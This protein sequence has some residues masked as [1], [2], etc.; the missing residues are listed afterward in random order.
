MLPKA[1]PAVFDGLSGDAAAKNTVSVAVTVIS[2]GINPVRV[3]EPDFCV[4]VRVSKVLVDV[5]GNRVGDL[6]VEVC[7]AND[8]IACVP[9]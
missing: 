1:T 7:R 9:F 6:V 8:P 5:S 4:F 3:L 2:C